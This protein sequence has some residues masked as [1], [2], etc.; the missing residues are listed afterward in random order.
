MCRDIVAGGSSERERRKRFGRNR[1]AQI[2]RGLGCGVAWLW[3]AAGGVAA[4]GPAGTR[5][6]DTASATQPAVKKDVPFGLNSKTMSG[7]WFG[8]GPAMR[9]LGIDI[10]YY[11]N[12]HFTNVMGGGRTTG[13]LKHSSTYDLFLLLDLE[14]MKL[15]KGG[16]VLLHARQ[17]WG[18]G[19]NPWVGSTQDFNDDAD[20]DHGIYVDQLYYRQHFWNRRIA[21]QIGYLDYQTIVDRNV[22]ANSED[23]QFMNTTLDNNPIIPTASMTGLGTAVTIKPVDWYSVILGTGDAQRFPLYKPGFSTAFHDEAWFIGYMEHNLQPKIPSRNGPLQGNYRIGMVY[24]PT[25][26]QVFRYRERPARFKGDDIG[27]Y[28]SFDQMLWRENGKDNQGLGGFFRYGWR[29]PDTYR[30]NNFWSLG[31]CYTGL[32]P[33]RDRDVLGFGFSQLDES[34]MYRKWRDRKAGNESVYEVYYAFEVTPWLVVTPDIQYIDNP[35]GNDS[36]SHAW[37]GGIRVRASF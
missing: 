13:D 21:W 28:L 30:F 34:F 27:L 37:A 4:Q 29:D 2:R 19:S 11:W 8:F 17:Q 3:V 14:K 23:K 7:D 33:T 18:R 20:G 10:Q 24:E 16:D 22:F 9:D 31:L 36:I 6:A 12:S 1:A 26:R 35:G 25:P 32:I 15:I 5:P